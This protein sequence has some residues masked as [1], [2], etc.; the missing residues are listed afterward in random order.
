MYKDILLAIDLN[1]ES[2][3]REALPAAVTLCQ[4]FGA[5][6]HVITVVPDYGLSQVSQYF[7]AGT[8]DKIIHDTAEQLRNFVARHIGDKIPVQDIVA[9]GTIHKEIIAAAER[10]DAGLI[11]MAS[12]RPEMKD[13]LIGPNAEKVMRHSDRSVLVVRNRETA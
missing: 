8:E 5:T 11:V 7:P 6:L 10:I 4:T 1:E 2:S 3:W 12:H 13:Y 9:H